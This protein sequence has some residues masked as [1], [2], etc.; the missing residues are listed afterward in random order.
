VLLAT[1]PGISQIAPDD[2]FP[3][4]VRYTAHGLRTLA[5]QVFPDAQVGAHG[6]V[7][8]AAAF[9]YGMA[10][11]EVDP[12]ALVADDPAYELLITLRALRA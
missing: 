5:E 11:D 4:H 6:N 8:A 9:L 3:D 7:H 12:R 10:E 2:A 1:V